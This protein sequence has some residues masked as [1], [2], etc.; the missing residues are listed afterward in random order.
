[1]ESDIYI[2][3]T[4]LNP[5][6][7][8]KGSISIVGTGPVA[9][10]LIGYTSG[11]GIGNVR[12]IGFESDNPFNFLSGSASG[13][14]K[15][16]KSMN[17]G[18]SVR[19]FNCSPNALY[20]GN[21]DVLVDATNDS[22]VK[23]ETYEIFIRNRIK[24]Y[25]SLVSDDR[26]AKIYIAEKLGSGRLNALI[27]SKPYH[28]NFSGKEQ[29]GINSGIIA[30]I[31]MDEIR[32]TISPRHDDVKSAGIFTYSINAPP[33][34]WKG[35]NPLMLFN[36]SEFSLADKRILLV[37]AGGIGTYAALGL[38][39]S[40]VSYVDIYDGDV[41][42]NKNR[43]RMIL[44]H[45]HV[46]EPKAEN[47]AR[48]LSEINKNAVFNGV[49][50]YLAPKSEKKKRKGYFEIERLGDYD[51]VLSCVDDPLAKAWLNDFAIEREIPFIDGGVGLF[52]GNV[53]TFYPGKTV[54]VKCRDSLEVIADFSRENSCNAISSNVVMPNAIVG[55]LMVDVA[56][57]ILSSP[58]NPL[59]HSD[60]S[61]NLK[62][63]ER[64][65]SASKIR[66]KDYLQGNTCKC[67]SLLEDDKTKVN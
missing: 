59:V 52:T 34:F 46:G 4:E 22:A 17:D 11:L 64:K 35:N 56:A 50:A 1:M 47:L 19:G 25:I 21:P 27:N 62:S 33:Y 20:V 9:N 31:A 37:G 58:Q 44:Y 6:M 29:D 8:E 67:V 48:K 14:E 41:V 36:D 66:N 39:M 28:L 60:I 5:S 12:I 3:N 43:N 57:A 53:N 26:V 23:E 7:L 13:L 16:L 54:C 49:N 55:F 30:A 2:N 61:L 51:I 38:A 15:A 18:I 63:S 10:Y 40:D 65:I 45:N 24:K 32:K 42:E